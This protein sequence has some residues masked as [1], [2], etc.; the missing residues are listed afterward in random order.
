[1]SDERR[2]EINDVM[3]HDM[4]TRV[5]IGKGYVSMLLNHYEAMSPD[6]RAAALHGIAEAF[7][8]LAEFTSRVLTDE[9]LEL[10]GVEPQCGEVPVAKLV[11]AA[12]ADYPDVEVTVAA[13]APATAFVDPVMVR[14]ILGNLLANARIAAPYGSQ[15]TLGVCR[16]AGLRFEV[17]DTGDGVT[18]DDLPLLFTRYGRTG[19]SIATH[20]PGLGLG[21][22]IVARMVA[23]HGGTYGVDTTN[24]TTF[25]VDLPVSG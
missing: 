17:H 23:A 12:R 10:Y 2:R 16:G 21:L 19:H 14:E 1:V 13:D 6:Q 4:R 3:R 11:E 20:A 15:V 22:S 7:D 5:G 18:K 9:K 8:R 25:W 24:G